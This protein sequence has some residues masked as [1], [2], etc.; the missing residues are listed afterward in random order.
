MQPAEP[1]LLVGEIG[2]SP[3]AQLETQLVEV[4]ERHIADRADWGRID[5]E[6]KKGLH[7]ELKRAATS[8]ADT[9]KSLATGL[10]LAKAPDGLDLDEVVKASVAHV[11]AKKSPVEPD[12]IAALQG[13]LRAWARARVHHSPSTPPRCIHP[14]RVLTPPLLPPCPCPLPPASPCPRLQRCW[15]RGAA[16]SRSCCATWTP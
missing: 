8:V 14:P 2:T 10:E 3:L 12:Q 7:E 1:G 5:D 6:S 11:K 4:Y 16:R 9:R 13:A 15:R